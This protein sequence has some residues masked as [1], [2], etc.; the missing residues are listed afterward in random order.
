MGN[1]RYPVVLFLTSFVVLMIGLLFKIQHW[2]G[3]QLITGSMWM[4]Q[5]ASIVWLIV[6]LARPNK[7]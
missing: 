4:V 5:I 7:K 1:F 6:L 3:A 2:P